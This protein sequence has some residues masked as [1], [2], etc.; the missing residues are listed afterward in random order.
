MTID[1]VAASG[2][3]TS[4][5][6][7]CHRLP[8]TAS[9]TPVRRTASSAR[10]HPDNWAL[11][12]KHRTPNPPNSRELDKLPMHP[13]RVDSR[14]TEDYFL[15]SVRPLPVFPYVSGG[16]RSPGRVVLLARGHLR[17]PQTTQTGSA[18]LVPSVPGADSIDSHLPAMT[19][20]ANPTRG[21]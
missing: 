13:P 7:G 5:T 10:D 6:R 9:T 11:L 4:P 17:E 18:L 3:R 16:A 19:A 1:T 21:I 20:R 8:M 15:A 14:K 12:S 2:R